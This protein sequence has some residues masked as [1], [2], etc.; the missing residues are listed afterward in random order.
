MDA[1]SW[2]AVD[3]YEKNL[4]KKVV[5]WLKEFPPAQLGTNLAEVGTDC[6]SRQAAIDALNEVVKDHSITDFDAIASILDLPSAQPESNYDEWC[7]DCKE[8][9]HENSCCPRWTKV[10]R[11]TRRELQDE[12]VMTAVDGTLWVTVDD[13]Q[14][15]GRVVVDENKSKFCR[16]FYLEE[17]QRTG[18]WIPQDHNKRVGNISTC[19]YYYPTC[20]ECGKVGNET[21]KYC[22]HCGAKMISEG[23]TCDCY[24]DGTCT[25]TK[26]ID[27]CSCGGDKSKCDFYDYV[28]EGANNDT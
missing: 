12:F 1:E 9:D 28:R 20:S 17:E 13:V 5:E 24:C 3:E 18:K 10:I 19:V 14:K 16:Q 25:G 2:V 21:Y 27:P 23:K 7:A 15:V 22:P 8:Y 6:I 26:E 4:Q 11:Q